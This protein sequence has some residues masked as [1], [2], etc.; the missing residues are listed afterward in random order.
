MSAMSENYACGGARGERV[1]TT[2]AAGRTTSSMEGAG[3]GVGAQKSASIG[4]CAS[5][6][7]NIGTAAI[8]VKANTAMQTKT[9]TLARGLTKG[10]VTT[11]FEAK[12]L[13]E[14]RRNGWRDLLKS[15]PSFCSES[16]AFRTSCNL[17]RGQSSS[18]SCAAKGRPAP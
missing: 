6:S 9:T 13:F 18:S 7:A 2:G 4:V 10:H 3:A 14:R 11:G 1:S 12:V 5:K 8:A 15:L 17:G 16:L